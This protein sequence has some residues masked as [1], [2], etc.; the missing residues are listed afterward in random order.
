MNKKKRRTPPLV[1]L[2]SPSLHIGH[3]QF[4]PPPLIFNIC[5]PLVPS[6]QSKYMLI[7][8]LLLKK[9]F[10][11]KISLHSYLIFKLFSMSLL[12]FTINYPP[13]KSPHSTPLLLSLVSSEIWFLLHLIHWECNLPPMSHVPQWAWPF[14][15][16]SVLLTTL[17]PFVKLSPD[18]TL[19]HCFSSSFHSLYHCCSLQLYPCLSSLVILYNLLG[20]VTDSPHPIV[21][22]CCRYLF[23]NIGFPLPMNQV[24][25]LTITFKALF[26]KA[27][28]S[29]TIP[30]PLS[31]LHTIT[32]APPK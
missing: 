4:Q 9:S 24:Q 31:H 8:S 25:L 3:H 27:P 2:I 7:S 13:K 12:S 10:K 14:S 19:A 16:M 30:V 22:P 28:A 6:S 23:K 20:E 11:N 5:S 1:F 29:W 17:A 15:S 18:N 21:W 32:P 26:S